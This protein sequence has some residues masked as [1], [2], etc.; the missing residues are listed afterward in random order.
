M[1]A[2]D[3][4]RD[5]GLQIIPDPKWLDA[6]KLPAR[7]IAGLFLFCVLLLALDYFTVVSLPGA[8]YRWRGQ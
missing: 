6:L 2:R 8:P 3:F 7:I 1:H 5:K 4:L